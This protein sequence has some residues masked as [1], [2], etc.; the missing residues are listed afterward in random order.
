MENNLDK[1][2]AKILIIDDD[3]NTTQLMKN[4][5][6]KEGY[7]SS[8]INISTNALPSAISINPDLILLDLMMPDIDGVE[9]CKVLH[10]EQNLSSVPIIFFSAMGDIENKVAAFKA[11]ASDYITKPIH[12][13]E[14][15]LRIKTWLGSSNRLVYKYELTH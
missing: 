9:L 14:F 8:S 12:I 13:E 2:A 5:L 4:I 3:I 11:G 10:S 1:I 6:T 7:E 15:K